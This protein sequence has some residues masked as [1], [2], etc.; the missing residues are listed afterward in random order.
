MKFRT[1][2][3]IKPHNERIDYQ[4]HILAVGSC[5]AEAIGG[6]LR[7]AKFD[8]GVN[9]TGVLFNPASIS[10]TL[11][12]FR[13]RELIVDTELHEGSQGWF[14]YDFHSSLSST[15][16]SECVKRINEA[17]EIGHE[18][19]MAADWIII[20]LGT[21]WIYEL[22]E[23]G[24]VV[25]NCHKQPSAKFRR[26][27][28]S[29]A[30]VVEWLESALSEFLSTKRVI[31]TLS[32]IRHLADGAAENSLSK[33]TLRVAIDEF[34]ARHATKVSYFP[35]FEIFMDDLRDYR[36][37]KEDMVHPSFVGE[38]Y[39]WERFSENILS[40]ETNGLM[41]K[42]LSVQRAMHHRPLHPQSESHRRFCAEQLRVISQLEREVDMS[43]ER[44]YFTKGAE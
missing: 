15:S 6:R 13:N 29:V 9:P 10:G 35:A 18:R 4:S 8:I 14:H 31:L 38:E 20:T 39:V 36:F 21:A 30:E 37:Y 1:E 23:S 26:R 44:E 22:V 12:R 42:V 33:S 24:I 11:Q 34:V 5:F 27:R 43:Q 40:K 2:I 32:P 41:C 7:G 25:A 3:D 17:I 16:S 19:L 28:L